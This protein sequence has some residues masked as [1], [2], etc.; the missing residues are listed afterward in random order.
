M[1]GYKTLV[2]GQRVT[3]E[4]LGSYGAHGRKAVDRVRVV[5]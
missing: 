3:F 5:V 2:E 1:D 4:W